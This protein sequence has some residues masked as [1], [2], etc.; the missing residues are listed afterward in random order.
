M[1]QLK[2]PDFHKFMTELVEN[3]ALP[4]GSSRVR[5]QIG[6]IRFCID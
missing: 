4:A 2:G 6:L 3:M 1:F 5:L